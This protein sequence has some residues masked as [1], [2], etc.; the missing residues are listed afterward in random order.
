MARHFKRCRRTSPTSTM[1]VFVLPKWAK[2]KTSIDIGKCAMSSLPGHRCLLASWWTT[3]LTTSLPVLYN[4]HSISY[5]RWTHVSKP[6]QNT[7]LTHL[8]HT[9]LPIC[10]SRCPI[11]LA[12]TPFSMK[13]LANATNT[14]KTSQ[15]WFG[16]G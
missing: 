5:M 4:G 9:R 14:I 2:S 3:L 11:M 12:T 16:S 10:R 1:A 6:R 8:C 15:T 13:Y 7:P